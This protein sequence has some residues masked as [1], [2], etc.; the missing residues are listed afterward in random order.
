LSIAINFVGTRSGKKKMAP[1]QSCSAQCPCHSRE[2]LAGRTGIQ[3][4]ST[5]RI[6]FWIPACSAH[7][8]KYALTVTQAAGMPAEVPA[9][10]F[11]GMTGNVLR[12][13]DA[14][15]APAFAAL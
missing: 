15:A 1:G 5:I 12:S 10:P 11:A 13:I 14:I 2:G 3:A 7:Q 6:I 9:S 4:C 8:R